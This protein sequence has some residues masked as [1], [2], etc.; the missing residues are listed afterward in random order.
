MT[1]KTAGSK[2]DQSALLKWDIS[3]IPQ[4]STVESASLTFNVL[5]ITRS[6]YDI[7]EVMKDWVEN[8]VNWLEYSNNNIWT[9]TGAKNVP[10]DRGNLT[11]GT[12]AASSLGT[13]TIDLNAD[14]IAW[15]KAG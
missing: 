3:S 4:N 15:F 14:G 8:E 7:Y 1:V 6:L 2:K 13:Y 5:N 12:F 11:L 9:E 10:G